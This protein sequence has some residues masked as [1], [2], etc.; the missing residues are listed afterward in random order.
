MP[1]KAS[2][3]FGVSRTV[4]IEALPEDLPEDESY[5]MCS[6]LPS[7]AQPRSAYDR[8][9]CRPGRSFA[10]LGQQF[11]TTWISLSD[12]NGRYVDH[13]QLTITASGNTVTA[14]RWEEGF[15]SGGAP[16]HSIPLSIHWEHNVVE[17]VASALG[18]LLGTAA[19]AL[20]IL[21]VRTLQTSKGD[22]LAN[23]TREICDSVDDA[24]PARWQGNSRRHDEGAV[25]S[26]KY[27]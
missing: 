12:G 17:D 25:N 20:L 1:H 15:R 9:L 8:A 19:L 27:M 24:E 13:L 14:A 5:K 16:P 21:F 7:D 26:R 22:G 23:A 4:V 6:A 18:L 2:P 10:L 11:V 3:R